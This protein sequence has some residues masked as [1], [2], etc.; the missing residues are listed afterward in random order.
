[1][2]SVSRETLMYAEGTSSCLPHLAKHWEGFRCIKQYFHT[3]P[4][5]LFYL[6]STKPLLALSINKV[7]VLKVRE[8][9]KCTLT[10][11]L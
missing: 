2:L 5:M 1:M 8:I 7:V 6:N 10:V 11:T 3:N 9:E 4:A